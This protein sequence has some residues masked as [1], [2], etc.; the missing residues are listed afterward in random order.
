MDEKKATPNK[1]AALIEIREQIKGN[2]TNT[3]CRRLREALARFPIN[4]FEASRYLDIYHAPARVMQL[5]KRG[6][7][8]V[9]YWQRVETEAGVKHRV[10]EYVLIP[11][12]RDAQP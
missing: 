11:K 4:T 5:R 8:I 1:E 7:N 6:E 10:G 12:G 3:Q 9:T 2:S